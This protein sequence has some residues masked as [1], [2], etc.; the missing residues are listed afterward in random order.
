MLKNV[1]CKIQHFDIVEDIL[2]IYCIYNI[3]KQ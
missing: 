2:Y 1:T 3:L